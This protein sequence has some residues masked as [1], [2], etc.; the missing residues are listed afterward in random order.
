M[1]RFREETMRLKTINTTQSSIL[2][3]LEQL[4]SDK[5]VAATATENEAP[6]SSMVQELAA[7]NN[8]MAAVG[9]LL[10][11][12][13]KASTHP[14]KNATYEDID[15]AKADVRECRELLQATVSRLKRARPSNADAEESDTKRPAVANE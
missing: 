7:R 13:L 6:S 14:D 4:M 12:S 2:T 11:A 9:R 8:F 1:E 10:T 3:E 5:D 15:A